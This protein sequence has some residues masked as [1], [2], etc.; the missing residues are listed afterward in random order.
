MTPAVAP[1]SQSTAPSRSDTPA[2]SLRFEGQIEGLR[3]VAAW[4]V[5]LFHAEIGPFGGGFIGVDVFF[6]ISGYLI[7]SRMLKE[8]DG[9]RFSILDFYER[10]VRRIAPALLAALA[11]G[12]LFIFL[13]PPAQAGGIFKSLL[14]ALFSVANFYFYVTTNYF[15]DTSLNPFLHTW[16][17]S[18]EEQF[19]I[20]LPPFLLLATALAPRHRRTL[21][22]LIA[23][24][25]LGAAEYTVPR[26]PAA[27]FHMPWLRAWELLAGTLLA[28]SDLS[29]LGTGVRNALTAAGLALIAW[30]SVHFTEH[31]PFPGLTA[32][33][34]VLGSAAI[35][36]GC[37][38]RIGDLALGN[39]A[40]RFF[41][42][43]SY[44]FYLAH[45]LA[46][47]LVVTVLALSP[48]AK[49]LIVALTIAMAWLSWRFVET[50]FRRRKAGA[51]ASRARVFGGLAV[52]MTAVV[53]LGLCIGVL[54]RQWWT[55]SPGAM[56]YAAYLDEPSRELT[57]KDCWFDVA[58]PAFA[59]EPLGR[60]LTI[61]PG[62]PQVLLLGDSHALHLSKSVAEHVPGARVLTIPIAGC[63]PALGYDQSQ[64]CH[65]ALDLVLRQ[66]LDRNRDSIA[67]VILSAQ[68]RP[69]AMPALRD[70][71]RE[72]SRRGI[73]VIVLGPSPEYRIRVPLMLAYED[74]LSMPLAERAAK[75]DRFDVDALMQA[76]PAIRPYY[77]S[78]IAPFCEAGTHHCAT[79]VDGV[80]L[81]FDRDHLSASGARYALRESGLD[82]RW[83]AKVGQ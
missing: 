71:L 20:F 56:R 65:D 41:G 74:L 63:L 79:Q 7:S 22:I 49:V 16:S 3:A 35:I 12:A 83:T 75:Q 80:P 42:K 82:Q 17:L 69:D 51:P 28:S 43:I 53:A 14:A 64:R 8:I 21:L 6:V 40:M 59:I 25:S 81:Y 29:R 15:T 44:S 66:W 32:L 33:V 60:C 11:V 23:L 13:L 73:L 19:Y 78:M 34:P 4:L 47:S 39:S 61:V 38:S 37:G 54:A 36:A 10:R 1:G 76:D 24:L 72:L 31:T 52:A 9:G 18:V 5:L 57:M 62:Q 50:P 26:N 55:S 45:W 67:G 68:W 2:E 77:V 70:T 27:A 58:D 30:S 46:L 48:K